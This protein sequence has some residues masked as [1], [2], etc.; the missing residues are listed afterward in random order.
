[1]VPIDLSGSIDTK[2]DEKLV[3]PTNLIELENGVFTK[4]SVITKRY[5]YDALSTTVIDGSA[6]PTGEALSSLEDELLAFGSNKLYSYASGLDRWIDRGGFRSVDATAQDLIRNENEQSAVDGAE[7]EGLI[8][9]AWEDSSG[10][11][12][13]SVVD[14]GNDVVVLEDVQI[15]SSGLTPR[16]VGQ[17]KNLTVIYHDTVTGNVI[18]SR[19][20]STDSPSAFSSAVTVA[21]DINTSVGWMDVCEYDPN[22]D[23]AVIAYADT[24]NTV[25]VG[26]ITSTG[27]LGTLG[28]GFPDITTISSQAEDAITIYADLE[29]SADIIV[30]F[31]KNSDSSGLKVYRLGSDLTTTATTASGDATEIKRI[32]LVYNAAGNLE[33]YYEHSAA[34]T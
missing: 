2:T 26:Y 27:A 20:V 33:V 34:Q 15:T 6:L 29:T 25:K 12:R 32:G 24:S 13:A 4:G 19:Q 8:L 1:M 23:S 28:T 22:N 14:S 5:G 10:G 7:S 18:K 9:Y 3:L 11:I 30:S 16:C 21:S 31:S 17:G